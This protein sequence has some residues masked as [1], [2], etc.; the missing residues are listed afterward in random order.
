LIRKHF[1]FAKINAK[2]I[3][4]SRFSFSGRG[5]CLPSS[6]ARVATC[7][8]LITDSPMLMTGF[9]SS[10]PYRGYA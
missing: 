3:E 8:G 4:K 10:R 1:H 5:P 2:Q 7:N 6:W 9:S